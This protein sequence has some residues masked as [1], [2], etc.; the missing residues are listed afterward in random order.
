MKQFMNRKG[1]TMSENRKNYCHECDGTNGKHYPGCT[2]EGNGTKIGF[3]GNFLGAFCFT[4]ILIFGLFVTALLP[5]LGIFIIMLGAKI[6][7]V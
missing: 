1:E 7:G 4:F 3:N 5:P 2:N 6:T